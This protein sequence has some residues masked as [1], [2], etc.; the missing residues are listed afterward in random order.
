MSYSSRLTSPSIS[1]VSSHIPETGLTTLDDVPVND[2]LKNPPVDER[3]T[4]AASTIVSPISEVEEVDG[5]KQHTPISQAYSNLNT[6]TTYPDLTLFAPSELAVGLELESDAS[7]SSSDSRSRGTSTS[8]ISSEGSGREGPS[9]TVRSRATAGE[10]RTTAGDQTVAS[11]SASSPSEDVLALPRIRFP[12]D[13]TLR[14]F[15]FEPSVASTTRTQRTHHRRRSS[16]SSSRRRGVYKYRERGICKFVLIELYLLL[17]CIARDFFLIVA[18]CT[19][20][21]C[22][23]ILIGRPAM[24]S[25]LGRVRADVFD[26]E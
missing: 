16:G 24:M 23:V 17:I 18:L 13:E 4:E 6:P 20:F 2:I 22:M 1:P 8:S 12:A 5:S 15:L 7:L 10:T 26:E 19:G 21:A 3:P 9:S 11:S 14:T 25:L